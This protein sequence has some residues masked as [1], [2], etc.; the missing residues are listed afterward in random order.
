MS[1]LSM[2]L[3]TFVALDAGPDPAAAELERAIALLEALDTTAITIDADEETLESVL[4]RIGEQIPLQVDWQA[5]DM[6]AVSRDDPVTLALERAPLATALASICLQSGDVFERPIFDV[7]HEQVV[8]TTHESSARMRLTDVYDIRDLLAGD[9]AIEAARATLPPRPV[10]EEPDDEPAAP[11]GGGGAG[12]PALP[13]IPIP[14]RENAPPPRRLTPGEELMGLI[15]EHVDPDAWLAFG[16]TRAT[17]TEHDGALMVSAV[18]GTH[19]RLRD[20]L[21][22]LRRVHLSQVSLDVAIVDVPRPVFERLRRRHDLSSAAL[23]RALLAAGDGVVRW[24]TATAAAIDR[25]LSLGSRAEGV[26]IEVRLVPRFERETALLTLDIEATTKAGADARA[27]A[28]SVTIP[29]RNGGSVLEL[30][31]AEPAETVRLLVL[32]PRRH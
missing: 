3:V 4:E 16:G 15:V 2:L 21:R 19:R 27:V 24:R 10:A 22:R 25:Q 8:L 29:F 32:I 5:L 7:Y 6:I 20:A 28:T 9:D 30:P 1:L 17:I 12:A 18:P 26:E 13:A 31:A 14:S 11:A 23:G